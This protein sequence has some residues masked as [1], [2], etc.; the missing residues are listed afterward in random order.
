MESH[1]TTA[2]PAL[3]LETPSSASFAFG[4]LRASHS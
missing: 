3:S 2:I 1:V 4:F